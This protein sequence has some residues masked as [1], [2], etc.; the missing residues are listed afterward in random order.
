MGL[1]RP[2][3]GPF[4]Q[5]ARRPELCRPASPWRA[6]RPGRLPGLSPPGARP[7][8]TNLKKETGQGRGRQATLAAVEGRAR[9][10]PAAPPTA[11]TLPNPIHPPSPPDTRAPGRPRPRQASP[12]SVS[13]SRP[14]GVTQA[15][16]RPSRSPG[17]AR[18]VAPTVGRREGGW[19]DEVWAACVEAG[20]VEASPPLPPPPPPPPPPTTP[21]P[22]PTSSGKAHVANSGVARA[23][24]EA[25]NA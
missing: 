24:G 9:G 21:P 23:A 25:R 17:H 12:G 8:C 4:N 1:G 16:P 18:A 6:A 2:A 7:R 20:P 11:P 19:E 5:V 15:A 14:P 13:S 3:P 22:S 10:P